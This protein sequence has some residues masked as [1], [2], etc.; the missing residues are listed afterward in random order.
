MLRFSVLGYATLIVGMFPLELANTGLLI[1]DVV[2]AAI[3]AVLVWAAARGHA[4]AGALFAV[5]VAFSILA[6]IGQI[7]SGAPA[8]L[9][10]NPDMVTT[11]MKLADVATVILGVA[12]LAV[13]LR[14]RRRAL[15]QA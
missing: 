1:G 11:W 8:W 10:F 5:A 4:W 15:V 3:V 2:V 9:R 7:W 6:T 12:A 13:Y 14:G